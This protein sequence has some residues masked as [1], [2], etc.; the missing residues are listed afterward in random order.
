MIFDPFS[1]NLDGTGRA[2]FSSGGQINVI[3]QSRL[4][5][6]MAKMMA[7]VPQPNQSGDNANY[8]NTGTQRLNRNNIDAKIN[9]NRNERH[10]MWFK[11]SVMDALVEGDFSLGAAGGNCLCAGGGLGKGSTLVQIGGMGTTYTVSPTFLIDGV[12]GWTRFGQDVAPPD[13][14]TNFGLD[15]LGIPGTNGPDPRESGMHSGHLRLEIDDTGS[16]RGCIFETGKAE[17]GGNVPLVIGTHRS[18]LGVGRYVVIAIRHESGAVERQ[19]SRQ[20]DRYLGVWLCPVS[21]AD[22]PCSVRRRNIA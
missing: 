17:H 6:P 1:G 22:R 9:W 5:V 7:L 10:Q 16:P 2:V 13:L 3:P 21:N 15:T 20:T 12:L 8:F 19:V 4:N 14:G 11:Y 18:H